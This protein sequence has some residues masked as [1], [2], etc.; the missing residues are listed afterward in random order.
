M[1]RT[2]TGATCSEGLFHTPSKLAPSFG[3]SPLV[4]DGGFNHAY[5]GR[6]TGADSLGRFLLSPPLRCLREYDQ[7][8]RCKGFGQT[9][10]SS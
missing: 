5:R 8:G 7:R 4:G 1:T 9:N 10:G 2:T 3:L 6:G